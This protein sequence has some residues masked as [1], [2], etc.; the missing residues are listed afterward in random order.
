MYAIRSY[1]EKFSLIIRDSMANHFTA[2][3]LAALAD[4]YSSTVG[5]SA[6]SKFGDYMAEAM[7]QLHALMTEAAQ[8]T[9]DRMKN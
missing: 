6:M 7:P 4:F 5:K 1:Y 3:E 2:E 9:K 8:K